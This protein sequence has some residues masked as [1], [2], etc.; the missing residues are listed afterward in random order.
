MELQNVILGKKN[1]VAYITLN[2]PRRL[3]PMSVRTLTEITTA[4]DA[5]EKS[6]TETKVV[7]IRH[8]GR[9]FS[10]GHDMK[11]ILA[12]DNFD[13]IISSC[14]N[15]FRKIRSIPQPVIAQVNGLATAG[16]LQL[17]AA[18]DMA[19]CSTASKFQTPGAA[20]GSFCT[21]PAVFVSRSVSRKRAFEILFTSR[22][23]S[24]DEALAWGLVNNVVPAEELEATVDALANQLAG[25]SLENFRAG[26]QLFYMQLH[27][28]DFAALEY[29]SKVGVIN[30]GTK[31]AKEGINAFFEKRQPVF[32]DL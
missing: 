15:M 6:G 28:E 12:G 13:G 14:N 23:I 11:E 5:V 30:F 4:L 29:A 10:T 27:L 20:D 16:G 19:I 24:A 7:V 8:E 31:S 17:M 21:N 9:A 2:E 1:Q 26:K 32:T 22:F 25:Y 3:N 18:C